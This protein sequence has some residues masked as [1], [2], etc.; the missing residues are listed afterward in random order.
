LHDDS[1]KGAARFVGEVTDDATRSRRLRCCRRLGGH[2]SA[3]QKNGEQDPD[4]VDAKHR[5]I[6]IYLNCTLS[7]QISSRL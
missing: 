4:T 1:W 6:E 7:R 3:E 2:P 5:K